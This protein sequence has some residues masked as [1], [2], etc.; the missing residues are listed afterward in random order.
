[1]IIQVVKDELVANTSTL[2]RFR[3]AVSDVDRSF[4]D[5]VDLRVA[6]HPSETEVFLVTRVIAYALNYEPGLEFSNGLSNPDDPAIRLPGSNGKVSKW[7]DIGNPSAKRL[8]KASKSSDAVVIYTYKDP[9]NLKR[10]MEGEAIHRPEQIQIFSL[11]PKFLQ[12]VALFLKKDNAWQI[13]HNDGELVVSS[14]EESVL[15]SMTRH[16]LDS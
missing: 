14:G 15:S 10:E 12:S 11:D 6:M 13:I 1:L 16:S 8:H 3:L 5:S 9:E 4:Y 7:I 2:Y